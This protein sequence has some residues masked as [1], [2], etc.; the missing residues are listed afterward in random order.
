MTHED[1]IDEYLD[2][3]E[4][5]ANL[6]AEREK[7]KPLLKAGRNFGKTKDIY[8]GYSNKRTLSVSLLKQYVSDK[9]IDL[10]SSAKNSLNYTVV[11][12]MKPKK[13]KKNAN[14]KD[15]RHQATQSTQ[16]ANPA[17]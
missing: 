1:A 3:T 16:E 6:R 2:L 9:V 5:I 14:S 15:V 7:L 12:K 13:E 4:K 11:E 8:V 10:C 17:L